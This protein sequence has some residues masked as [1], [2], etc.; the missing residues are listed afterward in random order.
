MARL[1]TLLICAAL[2]GACSPDGGGGR[3]GRDGGIS[4]RDGAVPGRDGSLPTGPCMPPGSAADCGTGNDRE[5]ALRNSDSDRDGL[6]DHEE[7]CVYSTDACA[8]DS[9]GDG[10]T[11]LGEIRGSMTDPL[12]PSSTIP[13]DDFFIVLPFNGPDRPIRT[14]A[15]GTNINRADVYFL[16][17]TTGS[18]G[19]PIA[20]VTSSL[21]TIATALAERIPDVQMGVGQFRDFPFSS[22]SPFGGGANYGSPGDMAYEN[23]QNITNDVPSVQAALGRL[24]AGGGNDG[25]ESHVAALFHASLTMGATYNFM[26]SSW[27]LPPANCPAIPDDPAPRIG[28]PCF[29]AGAL[30]IFVMVTDVQMHDGP[31]GMEPY[32]NI[33][34]RPPV[35]DVAMSAVTS[36][37]AR[38]VG[39]AVDGGGRADMEEVA[40]RTGTIDMAGA[41]LVLNASGG[42][43]SDSI[44]D[45]IGTLVGGVVQDVS[46]RLENVPGNPGDTDATGFIKRVT[47]LEGY[48]E[49]I[50]GAGYA[51]KDETTFYQVIP[52]TR[53]EFEV[54]FYND[55]RVP[56]TEAA[57]IHRARII[58]IGNGVAELDAREVYIIVPPDGGV[59]LI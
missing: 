51:S 4:G 19:G 53:V 22:G 20:N 56:A 27:T 34:P 45:A 32:T 1:G 44:I 24:S 25:P 28:Y 52:G 50:A 23:M 48:R 59:I 8:I 12:D 47:P 10:I 2:A 16:I 41:P 6:T 49:G 46:T 31:M 15:F 36:I 11:D 21:T 39:V 9:D 55:F 29:R 42:A 40:R 57:E 14:L 26:G 58:V 13:D 5:E 30:P 35:F 33:S 37:G 18:M 17:D 3:P 43:V 38:F 7:F 54:E